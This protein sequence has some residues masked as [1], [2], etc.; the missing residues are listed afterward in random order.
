MFLPSNENIIMCCGK[1]VSLE[2][3]SIKEALSKGD[4]HISSKSDALLNVKWAN[5]SLS[6]PIGGALTAAQ[7]KRQRRDRRKVEAQPPTAPL[8]QTKNTEEQPP[9]EKMLDAL[10]LDT[11]KATPVECSKC[12]ELKPD[13]LG[14]SFNLSKDLKLS[15]A[16]NDLQSLIPFSIAAVASASLR[17]SK[18]ST[19]WRNWPLCSPRMRPK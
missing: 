4:K 19:R 16:D 12:K 10:T 7:K 2:Q 15:F 9:I 1:A 11:K 17:R 5:K 18:T 6:Q 8:E 14:V 3:I 13:N